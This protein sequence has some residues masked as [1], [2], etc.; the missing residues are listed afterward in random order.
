MPSQTAFRPLREEPHTLS[1]QVYQALLA[2]IIERRIAPGEAFAVVD[3]AAQLNVSR[4]PVRDALSRLT[5]E[6]LVQAKG[7]RGFQVIPLTAEDLTYLYETRLMCELFSVEKGL[8]VVTPRFLAELEG[9][10]DDYAALLSAPSPANEARAFLRDAEFHR[11]IVGLAANPRI[12]EI[13]ERLNIHINSA[14]VGPHPDGYANRQGLGRARHQ[15]VIAAL[16]TGDLAVA[17]Q[18]VREHIEGGRERTIASLRLGQVGGGE[19]LPGE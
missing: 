14:R 1:E 10:I 19:N 13:F 9:I 5:A 17:K 8:A 16:H 15:A 12:S 6:G 11:R 2:A 3:L 4:T 18:A 7:R